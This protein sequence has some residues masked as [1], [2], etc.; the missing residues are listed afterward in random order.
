MS[1]L[2]QDAPSELEALRTTVAQLRKELDA[3]DD[4]LAVVSHELKTPVTAM[5]LKF[6]TGRRLLQLQHGD[7]H[8][9]T[10]TKLFQ[11]GDHQLDRLVRLLDNLL[12]VSRTET[13]DLALCVEEFNLAELVREVCQ[14]FTENFTHAKST[15]VLDLDDSITGTWDRDRLDQVLTNLLTNALRYA[16]AS[17]VTM[18]LFR[19][20]GSATLTV[21]DTGP[22]ISR[23]HLPKLFD[24]YERGAFSH[25]QRGMG[26]GLF[27]SREIVLAHQGSI[28]VKSEPGRGARFCITLPLAPLGLVKQQ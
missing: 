28:T 22:G 13:G 16:P 23:E 4:F 7:A 21:S 14:R 10:L 17:Q 25:D 11:D 26:L 24:R 19:T 27:I 3:R 18:E 1:T 9:A 20:G 6:Q 8:R 15:L 12:D 2:R 5:K